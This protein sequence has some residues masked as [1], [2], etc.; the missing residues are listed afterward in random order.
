MS[1]L[2]ITTAGV[3]EPKVSGGEFLSADKKL[4]QMRAKTFNVTATLT[5]DGTVGDVMFVATKIEN[6]VAVKGGAC[7][8]QSVSCVLTDNASDDSGTGSNTLGSFKLVFTSN[9]QVLGAV[10]NPLADRV[11][12]GG[13]TGG[14]DNWS[15]A[16][17]DDTF[18]IVDVA[19]IIDM[20][21]LSVGSLAN[22]GAI[23]QAESDSRD[24]YVWGI[25]NSNDDYNGATLSLKIGLIQD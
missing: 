23:G 8:L 6:A 3:I 2:T 18:A 13:G 14:I 22:I 16:V 5:G 4:N 10:S 7:M 19:N 9:S 15:R 11:V 1:D 21:E 20:G 12:D 25:T 17:L 24:L